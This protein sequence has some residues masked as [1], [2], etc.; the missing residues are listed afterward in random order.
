MSKPASKPAPKQARSLKT[1]QRLLD[2]AEALLHKN[3]ISGL[4]IA[5]V[6]R[7]ARSSVGSFYA[8]FGDKDDLLRA[9]HRRKLQRVLDA[10]DALQPQ[11][12]TMPLEEAIAMCMEQL[13]LHHRSTAR[14]TAAFISRSANDPNAW[15]ET[16]ALHLRMV[17]RIAALL[18]T[19]QGTTTHADPARAMRFGL[20]LVFSFLGDLAVHG[21]AD[22]VSSPFPEDE[23]PRELTRI[24]VA[25]LQGGH[26]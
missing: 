14:S 10:L 6:V 19:A 22:D 25:Y 18:L 8:R 23:L 12:S 15:S 2:A 5:E 13:V 11:I 9:L 1:E 17:E 26:P 7:K 21:Q 24:L 16:I 20:H 4:S 3:G